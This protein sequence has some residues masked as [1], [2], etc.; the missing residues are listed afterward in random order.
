MIS[1][2]APADIPDALVQHAAHAATQHWEAEIAKGNTL[3]NPATITHGNVTTTTTQTPQGWA[4]T[5]C[6]A[7]GAP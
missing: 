2:T 1:V 6:K 4:V 5:V 7:G 3:P